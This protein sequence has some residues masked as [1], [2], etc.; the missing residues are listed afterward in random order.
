LTFTEINIISFEIC[1]VTTYISFMML[2]ISWCLVS[3]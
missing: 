1:H 3:S 2:E